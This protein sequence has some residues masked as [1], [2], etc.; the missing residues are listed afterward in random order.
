MKIQENLRNSLYHEEAGLYVNFSILYYKIIL[1]QAASKARKQ[2][3]C[4]KT[5]LYSKQD[6]E[7]PTYHQL[8]PLE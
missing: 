1:A 2:Y 7:I 4:K 3:R 5:E 6:M 8:S